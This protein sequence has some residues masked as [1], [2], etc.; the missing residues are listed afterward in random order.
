MKR[1]QTF[2]EGAARFSVAAAAPVRH[3]LVVFPHAG[4]GVDFYRSWRDCLPAHV[5]LIVMQYPGPTRSN[6]FPAWNDPREAIRRCMRGLASLLGIA[7]ITFFGHSMGALLALH[8]ASALVSSRFR[9]T[10]LVLSSQMTPPAL[11]A[12]LRTAQDLERLAQEALGLGEVADPARLDADLRAAVASAVT[13]DLGLLQ[14]LARR[15]V[16]DIPTTRIFGG[17]DDPLI[18]TEALADWSRFLQQSS[19]MEVFPGGHFY[20]RN[21][22]QAVVDAILKPHLAS[23]AA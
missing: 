11:L 18:G 5:D 23:L 20:H 6:A 13:R 17:R 3:Q 16:G 10:Q 4:G 8:V 21:Q 15:P 22:V 2:A 7:P 14:Q 9:V 19:E 1:L 12:T